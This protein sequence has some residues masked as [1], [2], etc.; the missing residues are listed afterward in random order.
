MFPA[1]LNLKENNTRRFQKCVRVCTCGSNNIVSI[2]SVESV[3]PW[4]EV[5]VFWGPFNG[6]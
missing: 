1:T 5:E 4:I 3:A 2:E 6:F